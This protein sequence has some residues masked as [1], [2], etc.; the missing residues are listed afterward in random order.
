MVDPVE[1]FLSS[2]LINMQNLVTASHTVYAHP[3][4]PNN[5]EDAGANS[6]RIGT[7]LTPRNTSVLHVLACR[8]WSLWVKPYMDIRR[9]SKKIFGDAGARLLGMEDVANP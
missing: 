6:L 9:R 2:S 7:W 1:I 8:I 3:G 4:S 5:L